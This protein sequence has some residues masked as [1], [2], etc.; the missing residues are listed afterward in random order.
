MLDKSAFA[1]LVTSSGWL[2]NPDSFQ[3]IKEMYANG[4]IIHR[5][6][7]ITRE[8]SFTQL[9]RWREENQLSFSTIYTSNIAE[10][11]HHTRGA[12]EKMIANIDRLA[13]PDTSVISAQKKTLLRG[14]E[15]P[16]QKITEGSHPRLSYERASRP[17]K[18]LMHGDAP[19]ALSF[20]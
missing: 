4:K 12:E 17:R 5:E 9:E 19:Q 13:S 11:L 7:D 6:L 14:G 10:W 1:D 20:N 16:V 15:R 2:S 3:A 18:R 8:D